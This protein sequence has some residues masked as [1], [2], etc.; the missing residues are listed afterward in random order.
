ME[1]QATDRVKRLV[2]EILE[3]NLVEINQLLSRLQ[4]RL[5]LSD[6][7]LN[8]SGGGGGGSNNAA[9]AQSDAGATKAA[10]VPA[11]EKEAFDIKLTVVDAKSKIKVI[12][13]VRAIT[14]LG[15]KE[16]KELVEKAPVVIKTGVKKDEIEAMKKI[17]LESGAQIEVI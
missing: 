16:A 17:L 15:L 9:A 13:E 4:S 14:G 10:A 6:A 11:K 5:G 12:K 7:M 2:D 3:L 1:K 8:F